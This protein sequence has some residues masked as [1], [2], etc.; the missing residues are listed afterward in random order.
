MDDRTWG[1]WLA[2][3]NWRDPAVMVPKVVAILLLG[4]QELGDIP[5]AVAAY[6]C[7][8]GRVRRLM[9]VLGAPDIA[10]LDLLTTGRNYVSDVFD[11][12]AKFEEPLTLEG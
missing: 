5:C 2:E 6:N 7:G 3:N 12:M 1:S 11:R 9:N 8:P 10:A 4:Y